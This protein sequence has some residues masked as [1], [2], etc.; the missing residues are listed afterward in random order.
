VAAVRS[1]QAAV[2]F[3]GFN[4]AARDD[5]VKTLGNK[6]VVQESPWACNILVT[7]E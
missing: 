1:G 6:A 5:I 4:P 2:E 3:R 7:S